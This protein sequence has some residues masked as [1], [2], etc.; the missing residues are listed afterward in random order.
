MQRGKK[1]VELTQE[2]KSRTPH[3]FAA[4]L[5]Q[6]A[7]HEAFWE[8]TEYLKRLIEDYENY[9][10]ILF[11]SEL[12]PSRCEELISKLDTFDHL[13]QILNGLKESI[14]LNDFKTLANS[15]FKVEKPTETSIEKVNQL[16]DIIKKHGKL[17]FDDISSNYFMMGKHL[18]LFAGILFNFYRKTDIETWK[19]QLASI[20]E[21]DLS[22]LIFL[23]ERLLKHKD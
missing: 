2:M 21:N 11:S 22:D 6:Y 10:E 9:R 23:A 13:T 1:I 5:R 16:L 15:I 18:T 14:E 12:L 3:E 20:P 19:L 4:A 8:Y 17:N 7:H